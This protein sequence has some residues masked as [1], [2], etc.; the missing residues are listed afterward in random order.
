L[1]CYSRLPGASPDA[2]KS[3]KGTV[4]RCVCTMCLC[5][6]LNYNSIVHDVF[7]ARA[8]MQ[9]VYFAGEWHN[10]LGDDRSTADF[11][12]L[13]IHVKIK[14]LHALT[15]WRIDRPDVEVIIRV[16]ARANAHL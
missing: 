12:A 3:S 10:P 13:P 7:R 6:L 2:R 8:A 14:C 9:D 15:E 16:C 1:I 11:H 5:S 4:S